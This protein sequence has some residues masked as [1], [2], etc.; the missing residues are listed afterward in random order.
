MSAGDLDTTVTRL[1]HIPTTQQ[2]LMPTTA[3]IE[4]PRIT[5]SS[6]FSPITNLTEV[7]DVA[8]IFLD[9]LQS[10]KCHLYDR[11]YDINIANVIYRG[12]DGQIYG[13]L[14]D[15]DSHSSVVSLTNALPRRR[16][17]TLV[18]MAVSV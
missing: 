13:V 14:G 17:D 16:K 10:N 5:L 7:K 6:C 8:Q 1:D 11:V 3:I 18:C 15:F 4:G 12:G 2:D 9:I